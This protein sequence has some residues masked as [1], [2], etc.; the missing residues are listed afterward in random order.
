MASSQDWLKYPGTVGRPVLAT[1]L[2][3]LSDDDEEL[4]PGEIGTIYLTRSTGER[5]EY[6]GDVEK[7]RS[8]YS[9]EYFTLGDVGFLN[10]DGFLFLSDRKA[11]VIIC[12]G[13]NVYSA[14]VERILMSCPAVADGT[15][16]GIPHDVLGEIVMALVKVRPGWAEDSSTTSTILSFMRKYLSSSKLPRRIEYAPELPRDM[17]GKMQKK[18][19]RKR[20]SEKRRPKLQNVN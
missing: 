14:E 13:L 15:V 10:E 3:I 11:D 16:F 5:F 17:T 19:L 7:T 1:K 20:Y 12:G 2:K 8:A 6:K 4:P 9:G 18:L